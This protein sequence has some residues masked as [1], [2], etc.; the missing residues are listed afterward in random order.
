MKIKEWTKNWGGGGQDRCPKKNFENQLNV[1]R[2][3]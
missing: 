3:V 1:R 2:K